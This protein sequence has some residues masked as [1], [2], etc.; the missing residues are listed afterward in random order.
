MNPVVCYN[1]GGVIKNQQITNL[2]IKNVDWA[3]I[4]ACWIKGKKCLHVLFT[5]QATMALEELVGT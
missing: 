5:Q 4:M 1:S 2:S 3:P